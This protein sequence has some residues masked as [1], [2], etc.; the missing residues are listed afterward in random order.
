MAANF[1]TL[2]AAKLTQLINFITVLGAS[3][4]TY[5]ISSLKC[6][7]AT[8]TQEFAPIKM[9]NLDFLWVVKLFR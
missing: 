6:S 1:D 7:T 9:V 4:E 8:W 2:V 5:F 3:Y